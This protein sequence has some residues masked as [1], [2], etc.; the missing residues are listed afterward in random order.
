LFPENGT[1]TPDAGAYIMVCNL[2]A[3]YY[4]LI[5]THSWELMK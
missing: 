1:E 5:Y 2:D 4:L 3:I